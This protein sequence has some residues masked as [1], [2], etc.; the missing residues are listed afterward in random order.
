MI[1]KLRRKFILILMLTVSLILLGVFASVFF[2]TYSGIMQSSETSL[3]MALLNTENPDENN[4]DN[5]SP[6][7]QP[8]SLDQQNLPDGQGDSGDPSRF[9]QS[10]EFGFSRMRTP[11]LV[12]SVDLNNVITTESNQLH[13]LE[14]SDIPVITELALEASA[15]SGSMTSYG[16]RYLKQTTDSGTRIAFVDNSV[17]KQVVQHFLFSALCVGIAALICFFILS[18]FLSRW[19]VRP[20]ARVWEQQ[21]QFVADASHE[22]KTPL[23]VILSNIDMLVKNASANKEDLRRMGYIREE[24]VRM[25]SLVENLLVL[26]QTDAER[27]HPVYSDVDFSYQVESCV[28]L[29]EPAIYEADKQISYEI[30]PKLMVS[31]DAAQLQQLVGILVDNAQKYCPEGGNIRVTLRKAEKK[32]ALL[33]V[34]NEGDPIPTEELNKVF[35]RF[36]RRDKSRQSHGGFGLGLSIALGIANAHK[37][38]IWAEGHDEGNSFHVQ[39]PLE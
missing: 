20:V 26:A 12:V 16:L 17:G 24:S 2:S 19:A 4:P 32:H 30:A 21:K 37:G 29:F 10:D 11:T 7:Q 22:L 9:M 15:D 33:S 31:G 13:F 36:Y 34:F 28:L 39:L 8:P 3:R 1:K 27:P 23:T 18:I 5:F 14:E 35:T 25:K 6:E 38:K